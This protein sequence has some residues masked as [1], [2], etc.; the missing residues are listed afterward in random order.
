MGSTSG[1]YPMKAVLINYNLKATST[2]Y[3]DLIEK[4]KTYN[5]WCHLGGS[6]WV[7]VSAHTPSQ[8]FA[9]L[10]PFVT[11]SEQLICLDI[12]NDDWHCD[13]YSLEVVDWLKTQLVQPIA[14]RW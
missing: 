2:K 3:G 13:G 4:I 12:S 5:S 1:R 7:V 8:V 6:V 9:V 14:S 11:D 10:R